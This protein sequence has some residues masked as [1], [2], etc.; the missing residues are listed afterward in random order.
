M[1]A[2]IVARETGAVDSM[3]REEKI[4]E[5]WSAT[6]PDFRGIAGETGSQAWPPEHRGKRTILVNTGDQGTILQLLE[7]LSDAEI[8]WLLPVSWSC[9]DRE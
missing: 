2:A 3:T 5:I 1:R 8:N 9:R 6:H 7:E 4:E